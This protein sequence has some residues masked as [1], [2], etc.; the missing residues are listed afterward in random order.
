[1]VAHKGPDL[2]ANLTVL[3][4]LLPVGYVSRIRESSKWIKEDSMQIRG[5]TD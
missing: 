3:L 1:M 5:H 2:E 4:S